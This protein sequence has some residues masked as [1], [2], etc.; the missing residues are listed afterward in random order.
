MKNE[1]IS[2]PAEDV[3]DASV[4]VEVEGFVDDWEEVELEDELEITVV[5]G[6]GVG[7]SIL[8]HAAI[9]GKLFP[10]HFKLLSANIRH[11]ACSS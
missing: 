7:K 6:A 8:N 3:V 2:G 9:A 5:V 10:F 11:A 1:L 4:E